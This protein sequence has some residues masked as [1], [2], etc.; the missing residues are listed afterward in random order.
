MPRSPRLANKAPVNM[1]VG[2]K[3]LNS[4]WEND[5]NHDRWQWPTI[6]DGPHT[7]TVVMTSDP[8]KTN[9]YIKILQYTMWMC[10]LN[11]LYFVNSV[12]IYEAFVFLK[13]CVWF[14][15]TTDVTTADRP[16]DDVISNLILCP[17]CPC[18]YPKQWRVG[19]CGN[20]DFSLFLTEFQKYFTHQQQRT[21]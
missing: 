5:V 10:H 9:E 12:L 1:Y 3:C 8:H 17:C 14:A 7:R 21:V 4:K 6:L 13:F 2:Y 16:S 15:M 19:F 11:Y 18:A 20:C